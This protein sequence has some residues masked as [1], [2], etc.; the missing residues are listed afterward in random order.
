MNEHPSGCGNGESCVCDASFVPPIPELEVT[1][2]G[3]GE[4]RC[5][6]SKVDVGRLQP[7]DSDDKSLDSDRDDIL[8]SF[9][10]SGARND[11]P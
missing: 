6:T 5:G 1:E 9:N 8:E 4:F 7:D 3:E 2:T 10:D 11:T